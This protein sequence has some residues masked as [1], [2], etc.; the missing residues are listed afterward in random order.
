M[1]GRPCRVDDGMALRF[2]VEICVYPWGAQPLVVGHHDREP[3]R[4]QS[5]DKPLFV[6]DHDVEPA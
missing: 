4:Q 2:A 3:S 1:L 5:G 6:V